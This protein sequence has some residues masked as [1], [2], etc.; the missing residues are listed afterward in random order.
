MR[1]Y[2]SSERRIGGSVEK[3]KGT[4][5]MFSAREM[6]ATRLRSRPRERACAYAAFGRR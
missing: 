3:G 5:H 2:C 6:K 4:V 1:I